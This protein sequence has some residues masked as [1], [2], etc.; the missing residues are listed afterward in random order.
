MGVTSNYNLP[1]PE[2]DTPVWSSAPIV[3]E[4]AEKIDAELS[5]GTNPHNHGE[6]ATGIAQNAADIAEIREQLAE[7][8]KGDDLPIIA[9]GLFVLGDANNAGEFSISN[10][11]LS[12]QE[13]AL[14]LNAVDASGAEANWA[15]VNVEDILQLAGADGEP[16]AKFTVVSSA[17]TSAKFWA[18]VGAYLGFTTRAATPTVMALELQEG[19]GTLVEG[20][21][22]TLTARS[23]GSG[24]VGEHDHDQYA[25]KGDLESLEAEMEL[26]AKTLES[27]EWK[28][29]GVP[30][31]RPGQMHL[32]FDQFSAQKNVLTIANED[33][34]GKTHGWS[35]VHEGDYI[36]LIDRTGEDT[37]NIGSDYA[38]FLVTK[39][40]KG[41]GIA[42]IDLDLYQ[43]QGD[44]LPDEVF[45]VRVLDIAESE[46]DMAALDERYIKKEA[47][48][49]TYKDWLLKAD[50]NK[51]NPDDLAS[52]SYVDTELG[53]KANTHSHNYASSSHTHSYAS[54]THTHDYSA[55][56]HTHSV[57]F[58]SGTST[59]PSLSKGEPFLNTTYN[60][61]YVGT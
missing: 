2:P 57:I 21:S 28:V 29:S 59:T 32:A 60:V 5:S 39:V 12:T 16:T 53:K 8:E 14:V 17:A 15:D 55:S 38:L 27:G 11:D 24:S 50:G 45:E 6:Y 49:S 1:F 51:K 30:M 40:E 9:S 31:V 54:T 58:R 47:A 36:E 10:F 43:G 37:R 56:N 13:Q 19:S 41:T 20:E 23:T 61:I 42:T 26:L 46:L 35:T 7:S 48:N 22:Y 25:T 34:G 4:L 18:S 44:C 33:L 52:K 3:Q